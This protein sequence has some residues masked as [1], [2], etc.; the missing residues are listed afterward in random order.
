MT[1]VWPAAETTQKIILGRVVP[2]PDD[3]ADTAHLSILNF[4]AE[5]NGH[6]TAITVHLGQEP[7]VRATLSGPRHPFRLLRSARRPRRRRGRGQC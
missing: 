6:V 5:T 2:I 1:D 4:P 7:P 3:L